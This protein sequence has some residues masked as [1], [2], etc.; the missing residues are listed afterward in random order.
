[1]KY[2]CPICGEDMLKPMPEELR[3]A[4]INAGLISEHKDPGGRELKFRDGRK[5]R[6]SDE[7]DACDEASL[8]DFLG[9][10]A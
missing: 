3:K 10:S 4:V 7:C 9:I 6:L 2:P 1:M 8:R 5:L